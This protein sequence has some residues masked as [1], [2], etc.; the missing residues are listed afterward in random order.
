MILTTTNTIEGHSIKNYLGVVSGVDVNMPKTTI[1]FN[2]EKYYENYENKINEVKEEAFQKLQD[3]AYKLGAN[4]V[5]GIALD[6]ETM[7]TSGIIIVSI[8]GTAVMVV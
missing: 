8:T 1:S 3:N 2:M 5:V 4:A 6:I 7:P